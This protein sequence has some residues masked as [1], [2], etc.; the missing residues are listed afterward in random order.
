MPFGQNLLTT[1][2][3]LVVGSVL[4]TMLGW[5]KWNFLALENVYREIKGIVKYANNKATNKP[6][7][8]ALIYVCGP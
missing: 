5:I 6:F 8:L 7:I 2:R 1:Y 3:R 4:D